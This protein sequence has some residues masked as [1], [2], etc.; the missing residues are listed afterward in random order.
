MRFAFIAVERAHYPIRVMCRVLQ[1]SR[2]GFY[3][4]L[5]SCPRGQPPLQR[6]L[7]RQI[8]SVF[9]Q[10]R[11]T[12]GSPRI[13]AQLRRQGL[14]VGKNRVAA[15][16]RQGRLH[17][18][19]VKRFRVPRASSSAP[20][21]PHLLRR[22]FSATRPNQKWASDI[23]YVRTGQGWLFVAVLWDLFSRLVVGWAFS[24]WINAQLVTDALQMALDRRLVRP[25]LLIHTDQGLQYA[26][27]LYQQRLRSVGA[28]G[29]MSRRGNCW[30]NAVV[31]SFFASL[32]K[33]LVRRR[34]FATQARLE[35]FDYIEVFYNRVRI[36]STLG[37]RSPYDYEQ[38]A[39]RGPFV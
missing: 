33:D 1:V 38:Q 7:M 27:T 10:S 14:V 32:K 21:A 26:S 31:E 9:R 35:I 25:G 15:L 24:R 12:Y 22:D 23:T 36:H 16:M 19:P 20:P 8:Q 18:Q 3:R 4:Y 30:D 6:Q 13:T 39:H 34:S 5:A 37:Y 29:S 17:A 11:G 28:V 2:S